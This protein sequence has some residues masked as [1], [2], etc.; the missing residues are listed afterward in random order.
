MSLQQHHD[1]GHPLHEMSIVRADV[2]PIEFTAETDGFYSHPNAEPTYTPAPTCAL[3]GIA[4]D[5]SRIEPLDPDGLWQLKY[6][7]PGRFFEKPPVRGLS[8][9][10]TQALISEYRT[11]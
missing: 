11:R 6:A 2:G 5:V 7:I 3:R 1:P 4:R 10:E 8:I 9:P